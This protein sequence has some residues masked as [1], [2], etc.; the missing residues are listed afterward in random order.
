MAKDVAVTVPQFLCFSSQTAQT[1]LESSCR[2]GLGF[3]RGRWRA[4][5]AHFLLVTEEF[6]PL[7]PPLFLNFHMW[8]NKVKF[9][10]GDWCSPN[11]NQMVCVGVYGSSSGLVPCVLGSGEFYT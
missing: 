8:R 5:W 3:Q 1:G 11:D 2:G 10:S 7:A 9:S 4:C 6:I